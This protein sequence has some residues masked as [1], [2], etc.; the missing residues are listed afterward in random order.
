MRDSI[1]FTVDLSDEKDTEIL[2][3]VTGQPNPIPNITGEEQVEFEVTLPSKFEVC[4]TCEG[5]GKHVNRNIDGNGLTREDFEEDPDFEE[6][7]FR[8]DYDVSCEE[9]DGQR[10]FPV[11]DEAQANAKLLKLYQDDQQAE[12][13]SRAEDRYWARL[14]SGGEY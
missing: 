12:A 3:L 4:P 1:K 14:E 10:V 9:C 11:V 8:G 7:Y 5:R 13:E 6:A 2:Q